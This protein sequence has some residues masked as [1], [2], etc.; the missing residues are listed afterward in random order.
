MA[1]LW[2]LMSMQLLFRSAALLLLLLLAACSETVGNHLEGR[3]AEG[4]SYA[5]IMPAKLELA[6]TS[7]VDR[8]TSVAG[9]NVQQGQ[10]AGVGIGRLFELIQTKRVLLVDCRPTIFYRMG[11]IDDAINLPLK[12]Y[13][14]SANMIRTHFDHALTERKVIVLYCQNMDCPDGYLF[15]KKI[16]EEGYSVSV[17]K[18]GWQEWKA[19]GL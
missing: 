18:G 14:K 1:P 7:N 16:A 9:G 17:Y 19:S 5:E 11:H 8:L 2:Y 4:G 12:K 3:V 6:P 10:I 15:A 13:A